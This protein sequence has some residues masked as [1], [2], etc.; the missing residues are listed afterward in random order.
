M[1][2]G[3]S[4]CRCLERWLLA[5]NQDPNDDS[6]W[7]PPQRH[8]QEKSDHKNCIHEIVMCE[9]C[10]EDCGERYFKEKIL[11]NPVQPIFIDSWKLGDPRFNDCDNPLFAPHVE[12]F[13]DWRD[14][15]TAEAFREFVYYSKNAYGNEEDKCSACTELRHH[16]EKVLQLRATE[17]RKKTKTGDQREVDL[18]Q[19]EEFRD[20]KSRLQA[21]DIDDFKEVDFEHCTEDI[22]LDLS[23]KLINLAKDKYP[24]EKREVFGIDKKEEE[25][26]KLQQIK[27]KEKQERKRQRRKANKAQAAAEKKESM[28]KSASQSSLPSQEK[29]PQ[30][31]SD[32][33]DDDDDPIEPIKIERDEKKGIISVIVTKVSLPVH[34]Y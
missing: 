23:E 9:K 12:P 33:D 17:C 31:F 19:L 16:K 32:V 1:R 30:S 24:E 18:T 2:F 34:K 3:G 6:Y 8:I 11:G 26:R 13:S 14:C 29:K 20:L 25:L 21:L 4:I 28:A 5:P 22:A 10:I 15:V 7:V 27:K